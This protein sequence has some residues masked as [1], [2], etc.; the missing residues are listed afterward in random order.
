MIIKYEPGAQHVLWLGRT[1]EAIDYLEAN[2]EVLHFK[3]P[4]NIRDRD[5]HQSAVSID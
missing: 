2:L 4:A 1:P 3:T 5:L